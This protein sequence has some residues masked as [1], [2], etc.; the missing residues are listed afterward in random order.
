MLWNRWMN[1]EA[2]FFI[3]CRCSIQKSSLLKL[4]KFLMI[5]SAINILILPLLNLNIS[6]MRYT[7]IQ[8]L[9]NFIHLIM[10]IWQFLIII[11]RI[12]LFFNHHYILF[13]FF[14]IWTNFLFKIICIGL[15]R[16][17]RILKVIYRL[18]VF[19]QFDSLMY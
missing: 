9:L 1:Y 16:H 12:V 7:I 4:I 19:Q 14:I 8:M 15:K 17:L 6:K 18:R 11:L 13:V 2:P 10:L 3:F 5:A